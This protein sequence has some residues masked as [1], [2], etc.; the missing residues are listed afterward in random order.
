[1]S[2]NPSCQ[3]FLDRLEDFLEGRLTGEARR[4]AEVH[5]SECPRC[6]ALRAAFEES[7]ELA[8]ARRAATG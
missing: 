2:V 5:S 1:M 8:W 7:V 3:S 6:R 4:A